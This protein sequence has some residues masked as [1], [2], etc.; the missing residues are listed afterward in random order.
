MESLAKSGEEQNSLQFSSDSLSYALL[1]SNTS[2][3]VIGLVWIAKSFFFPSEKEFEFVGFK[4]LKELEDVR[5]SV[6]DVDDDVGQFSVFGSDKAIKKKKEEERITKTRMKEDE[7]V[8]MMP[9]ERKASRI[10]SEGKKKLKEKA[11]KRE[12]F[13]V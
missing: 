6:V 3:L 5:R 1:F 13:D 8:E 10:T 2:V 9:I 12:N 7:E 4:T 11:R